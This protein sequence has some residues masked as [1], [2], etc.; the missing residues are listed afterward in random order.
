MGSE[1]AWGNVFRE[2]DKEPLNE[3]EEVALKMITR[4]ANKRIPMPNT[5]C[6]QFSMLWINGE[7]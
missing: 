2:N 7:K 6:A 4:E 5:L 1:T 3:V